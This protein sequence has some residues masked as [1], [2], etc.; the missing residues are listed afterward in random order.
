MSLSYA[1]KGFLYSIRK[2]RLM[3][4]VPKLR[5]QAWR[6]THEGGRRVPTPGL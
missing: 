4:E 6:P 1:S 5:S 3:T 2:L